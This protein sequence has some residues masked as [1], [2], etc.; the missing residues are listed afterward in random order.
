MEALQRQLEAQRELTV[1]QA[2]LGMAHAWE[3][4]LRGPPQVANSADGATCEGEHQAKLEGQEWDLLL[5]NLEAE[6]GHTIEG[7]QRELQQCQARLAKHEA[8]PEGEPSPDDLCGAWEEVEAW[9]PWKA[10]GLRGV[11]L[12][13]PPTP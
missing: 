3:P 12:Q 8:S 6:Y 9:L 10:S 13:N 5:K 1:A 11:C 7:L 4:P 2:E